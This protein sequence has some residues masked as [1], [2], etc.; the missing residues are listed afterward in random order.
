M[1]KVFHKIGFIGAGNMGQAMIGALIK[2]QSSASSDLFVCDI[3]KKQT[4]ALQKTYGIKVLPDNSTLIETCDVIIFA[5]K[6]QSVEQVLSELKATTI[7]KKTSGKKIFI[8][9]AAGT[10]IKKFETNI[11][12]GLEDD[13]KNQMPILRVMPNTPALVL[14]GMS[15]LCANSFATAEDVQIA[16]TILSAMGKVIECPESDMDA[17]TAVSGS[18]PAYCFYLVEAMIEA[19]VTLGISPENAAEMT[20]ATLKGSMILLEH[21]SITAKELRQKVTSPGGTTEAAI[22]VLD[23]NSVKQI[24]IAAVTAAAQRSKELSD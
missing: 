23:D 11:Y 18:G 7:F 3:I 19:A 5:V 2:S 13:K 12:D 1:P 21:Q 14:S 16:K 8:S 17:V 24:I 20:A 10:P 15:G 22:K 6:P 4:D 9:I